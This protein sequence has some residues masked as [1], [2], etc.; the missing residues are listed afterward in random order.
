MRRFLFLAA[1]LAALGARGDDDDGDDDAPER[2]FLLRIDGRDAFFDLGRAVG[3]APGSRVRVL[4]AVS[5]LQPITRRVVK[6]SFFVTELRVAEAGQVLSRARPEPDVA[7][8]LRV[9]DEVEL[10]TPAPSTASTP[11][12]EARAQAVACPPTQRAPEADEALGFRDTWLRLQGLEASARA[13]Q[14]SGW[15]DRNPRSPMGAAVRREIEALR[16]EP[17]TPATS[18]EKPAEDSLPAPRIVAPARAFAGDPIEVVLAFGD[19]L[20]GA[21]PQAASLNWRGK[22]ESIYRTVAFAKGGAATWR[23]RLPD[24]AAKV[25]GVDYFVEMV[26]QRGVERAVGGSGAHPLVVEVQRPPGVESVSRHERSRTGL[27]VDFVDWNRLRGNDQHWTVEGEFLYRVLAPALYS[28][29]LGF[30]VYQGYG[31]SLSEAIRAETAAGSGAPDYRARRVGYHYGFTE[32]EVRSGE[33]FSL[34]SKVL[35]G[36]NR[37]GFLGGVAGSIRIGREQ[38]TNLLLSSGF[39]PGIGNRNEIALT[40]DQVKGWPM[41]ASVIVTNE[42]V[43]EDYGVRFVYSVGR[44]LA[45][46]YDLSLRLSYQLRD[47]NHNGFGLGVAQ[48]FH[49]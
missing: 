39:T 38:G 17:L 11:A 29:R 20:A 32:L 37:G 1:A 40:W 24:D 5:A 13:D 14:W 4:R 9:G 18:R 12:A 10:V 30:G 42:P 35:T 16:S 34:I 41:A 3:A 27:W 49:W 46:F 36:V 8:L 45:D 44:R 22:G 6:E 2:A 47:I 21:A 33:Y 31:Q 43:Q 15:L 25:P 26:G 19:A 48:T 23:A 28:L 7:R